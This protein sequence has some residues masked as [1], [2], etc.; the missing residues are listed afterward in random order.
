MRQVPSKNVNNMAT[1]TSSQFRP[2]INTSIL[3][4]DKTSCAEYKPLADLD[5]LSNFPVVIVTVLEEYS[6]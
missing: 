6:V 3:S 4:R 2:S 1:H 5:I